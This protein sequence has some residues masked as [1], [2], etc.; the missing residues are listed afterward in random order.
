MTR[1]DWS[2]L[3]NQILDKLDDISGR[4]SYKPNLQ[5]N[6][7]LMDEHKRNNARLFEQIEREKEN[8][9]ILAAKL[10]AAKEAWGKQGRFR[11]LLTSSPDFESMGKA[12]RQ[13]EEKITKQEEAE[14]Q[15]WAN[16][17]SDRQAC[18]R[19]ERYVQENKQAES[20][21]KKCGSLRDRLMNIREAC[22]QEIFNPPS[23]SL[24]EAVELRD[25]DFLDA[26][27]NNMAGI[28]DYIRDV[29]PC[30]LA[31]LVAEE[32]TKRFF[33]DEINLNDSGDNKACADYRRRTKV[34]LSSM[35]RLSNDESSS[36]FVPQSLRNPHG[37]KNTQQWLVF[38]TAMSA[39][40]GL[41]RSSSGNESEDVHTQNWIAKWK[42]QTSSWSAIVRDTLRCD[43]AFIYSP[44]QSAKGETESGADVMLALCFYAEAGCTIRLAYIQFK[45]TPT[46]QCI[47]QVKVVHKDSF[48]Q[49]ERLSR[50]HE[51]E[52]GSSA[53]Y[54]MFSPKLDFIEIVSAMDVVT[55]KRAINLKIGNDAEA[56]HDSWGIQDGKVE[57]TVNAESMPTMLAKALS[58]A[59]DGGGFASVDDAISWIDDRLDRTSVQ[60][61]YWIIQAVGDTDIAL[62]RRHG[63]L[64]DVFCQRA[65]KLLLKYKYEERRLRGHEPDV[66]SMGMGH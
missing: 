33:S 26:L 11:K 55:V 25:D 8:K 32:E 61:T 60:P 10:Q 42:A 30:E 18:A 4:I 14:R 29:Q 48:D 50:W 46:D 34:S 52:R 53:L 20:R 7:V 15:A 38:W 27:E 12:I 63:N 45:R 39:S 5:A 59:G 54:G 47:S 51:P 35:S 6:M 41:S 57:W 22:K 31:G 64:G 9:A 28:E 19:A 16:I 24:D 17:Q 43:P 66:S 58:P 13:T 62:N 56:S 1:T 40:V 44:M 2:A 37:W 3:I 21:K 23:G 49:Y 36:Q 65:K